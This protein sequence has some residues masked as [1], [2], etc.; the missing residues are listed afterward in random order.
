MEIQTDEKK[1]EILITGQEL[2]E[3]CLPGEGDNTCIW[4]MSGEKGFECAYFNRPTALFERWAMG[5]TMAKRDGCE[6]VKALDYKIRYVEAH[7]L[8][9]ILEGCP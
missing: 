8:A 1:T 3:H 7:T 5:E 2:K 4:A 9:D 6:R